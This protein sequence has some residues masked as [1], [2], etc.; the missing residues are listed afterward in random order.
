MHAH[1]PPSAGS[2]TNLH[3]QDSSMRGAHIVFARTCT[4]ADVGAEDVCQ[5][6]IEA[7]TAPTQLSSSNLILSDPGCYDTFKFQTPGLNLMADCQ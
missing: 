4:H 1:T 3:V 7:Y 5:L 2:S 6:E